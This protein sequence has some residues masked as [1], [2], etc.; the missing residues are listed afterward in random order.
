M[1]PCG[2]KHHPQ[3]V[4][5]DCRD[6]DLRTWSERTRAFAL[7]CIERKVNSVL[8]DAADCN[9]D[10][11]YALRDALT[12]L[13]LTGIPAGFRLALVTNVSRLQAFFGTL[14]R[15]LQWLQ[16]QARCFADEAEALEWLL[17]AAAARSTA[18]QNSARQEA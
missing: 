15:D 14:Q 13:I 6:A 2:I 1:D 9:A 16:I 12:T 11:H 3:Y 7:A 8:I 10:G 4:A 17:G 5:V 18:A